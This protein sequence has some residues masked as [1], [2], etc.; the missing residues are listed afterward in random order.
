ML[1]YVC[2]RCIRFPEEEPR[3]VVVAINQNAAE[4]FIEN[5]GWRTVMTHT[6]HQQAMNHADMLNN[7]K[8]VEVEY[9]KEGENIVGYK[10]V[11]VGG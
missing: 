2:R 10:M 4:N 5:I 7:G 1:K 9:I 11:E 8:V 6:D 3:W